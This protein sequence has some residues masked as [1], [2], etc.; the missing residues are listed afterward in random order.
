MPLFGLVHQCS[1]DDDHFFT[2]TAGLSRSR[3]RSSGMEQRISTDFSA[4]VKP[5][6]NTPA[7]STVYPLV[8]PSENRRRPSP[9]KT[10][11]SP[12]G[13]NGAGCTIHR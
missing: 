7:D 2:P 10:A 8:Y 1:G 3:Y 11:T 5:A 12:P 4:S 13:S 6:E 9:L